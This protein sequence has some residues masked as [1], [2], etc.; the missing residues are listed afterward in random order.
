M[1][2]AF[3]TPRNHR[4]KESIVAQYPEGTRYDPRTGER[5]HVVRVR[6]S[7]F[8]TSDRDE[9]TVTYGPATK[10]EC[11]RV[12]D[13]ANAYYGPGSTSWSYVDEA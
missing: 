10:A 4:Y 12:A 5:L 2:V 9:P 11:E 3:F 1:K 13:D 7:G 6:H 8:M